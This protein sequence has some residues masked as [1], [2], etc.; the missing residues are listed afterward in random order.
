M[1]IQV[2]VEL[3]LPP[4]TSLDYLFNSDSVTFGIQT[5]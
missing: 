1:L 4:H 2:H 3:V 5:V